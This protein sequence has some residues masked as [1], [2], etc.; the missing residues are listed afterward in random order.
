LGGINLWGK[1][2]YWIGYW[3]K[4]HSKGPQTKGRLE[5]PNQGNQGEGDYFWVGEKTLK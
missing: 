5:G 2:G 3:L 4:A 1:G